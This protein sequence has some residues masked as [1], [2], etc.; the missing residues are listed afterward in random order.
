MAGAA[1]GV[2]QT[3]LQLFFVLTV[4]QQRQGLLLAELFAGICGAASEHF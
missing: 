4:A 1:S 2:S 3:V